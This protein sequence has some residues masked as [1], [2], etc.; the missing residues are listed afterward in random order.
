M[1]VIEKWLTYTD[2]Q[3]QLIVALD[4]PDAEKFLKDK[5]FIKGEGKTNSHIWTFGGTNA[6]IRFASGTAGVT[7]LSK[8]KE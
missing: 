5:H 6:V 7:A 2:T 1:V 3:S 8:E 4:I